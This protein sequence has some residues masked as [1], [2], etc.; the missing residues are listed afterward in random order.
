M[1]LMLIFQL[2]RMV[3]AAAVPTA[4]IMGLRYLNRRWHLQLTA[5]ETQQIAAYAREAVLAAEQKYKFAPETPDTNQ[6]KLDYAS[7]YMFERLRRAAITL[8]RQTVVGV[9][10]AQLHGMRRPEAVTA[11]SPST[12]HPEELLPREQ[13]SLAWT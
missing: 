9:I 12:A 5:L 13:R 11:A 2:A 4:A 10:E 7:C 8:S 3:T 1:L 6:Q